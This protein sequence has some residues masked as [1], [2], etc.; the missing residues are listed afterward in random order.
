MKILIASLLALLFLAGCASDDR[1][2]PMSGELATDPVSG[3]EV[4]TDTPWRTTWGG[5]W[6]YFDSEEN[7]RTFEVDP[8]RYAASREPHPQERRTLHPYDVR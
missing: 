8:P 1:P 6:Y 5:D 4:Q 7:L 2:R 3:V